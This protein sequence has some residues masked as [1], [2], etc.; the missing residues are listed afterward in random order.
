MDIQLD[1]ITRDRARKSGKAQASKQGRATTGKQSEKSFGLKL[2]ETQRAALREELDTLLSSI[3]EQAQKIEKSLTFESLEAYREL[4]KKFVGIA[5]NE[6]YAVEEKLSVSKT[7]KKKSLL[8]VKKLDEELETLTHE[9]LNRQ[10][11][12]VAFLGR[13]DKIRGLLL[14]LYS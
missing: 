7:G 13:L 8:I 3:D 4:I 14:D 12:L 5:V 6:L 2:L 1:R 10:Q 9:F 11:N